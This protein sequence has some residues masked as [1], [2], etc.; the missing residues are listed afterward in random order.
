MSK[1]FYE[2]FAAVVAVAV[3]GVV[4]QPHVTWQE[5]T[6]RNGMWRNNQLDRAVNRC[7]WTELDMT[8]EGLNLGGIWC[9]FQVEGTKR[10]KAKPYI[11]K[12]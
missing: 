9:D 6:G 12:I 10:L 5:C 2:P 11:L 4:A 8:V 7:N 1:I 3:A